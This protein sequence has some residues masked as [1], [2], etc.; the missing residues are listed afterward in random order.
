M[1]QPLFWL[2]WPTTK[3]VRSTLVGIRTVEV[4]WWATELTLSNPGT[5]SPVGY[6]RFF[7]S[8]CNVRERCTGDDRG[9]N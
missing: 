8:K 4:S 5:V 9:G 6:D 2:W 1:R 7:L 3:P